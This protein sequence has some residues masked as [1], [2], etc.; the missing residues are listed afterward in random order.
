[1]SFRQLYG[2]ESGYYLASTHYVTLPTNVTI[3][4][5]VSS[6]AGSTTTPDTR[7]YGNVYQVTPWYEDYSLTCGGPYYSN[8]VSYAY[9][10]LSNYNWYGYDS[11]CNYVE[12]YFDYAGFYGYP[13]Y[14]YWYGRITYG[15]GGLGVGNNA[16]IFAVYTY[17]TTGQT[18]GYAPFIDYGS[19]SSVINNNT[20]G[21]IANTPNGYNQVVSTG[22]GSFSGVSQ[23]RLELGQAN[24]NYG[25]SGY[26]AYYG[27]SG[28]ARIWYGT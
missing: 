8:P 14:E 27:P 20:G 18:G 2:G 17:Q 19:P 9:R 26:E 21:Y 28:R 7:T 22:G 23:I 13:S 4:Y 3:N 5:S 12:G 11:N 1:L 10:S 15:S 25:I 16:I 24:F 6:G